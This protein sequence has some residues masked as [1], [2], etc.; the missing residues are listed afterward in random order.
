MESSGHGCPASTV[1]HRGV[2]MQIGIMGLGY[3]G[4]PLAVA[5]AEAGETVIGVD[6]DGRRVEALRQGRSF[7]EDIDD[8]RLAGIA[9]RFTATTRPAALALADAVIICVPTPLTPNR[10]PDLTPL[11]DAGRTLASVLQ[12]GQLVVLES[13]TYPGTTRERLAPLLEESGLAAGRDFALAF[14]PE[15]IDP[16]RG[17]ESFHTTPKVV[18]G[19]TATCGDRAEALYG[20]VVEAVVRVS[21]PEVAEM[22]KLLENIFRSV[23][24]ALVNELAE[25]A[26]RMGIEIHEV[27]DAAA[28]KPY[29]FMRFD[30]G[31]G[32]GGHC[33][34]VDPFYLSWKARELE[35][36]TEFIEL[37]GKVNQQAP[38]V[39]VDKVQRRLNELG[40]AVRGAKVAR[41]RRRLQARPLRRPRVARAEDPGAAAGARGR[42]GLPRRAGAVAAGPRPGERLAEDVLADCDVAVLVTPQP[43]ID[44]HAIADR[45]PFVDLRGITRT[46]RAELRPTGLRV[47]AEVPPVAP[48]AEA[49]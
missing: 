40:T 6:V 20:R 43:G 27:V 10:E 5:F 17:Q 1:S 3:V 41:P 8:E 36:C 7:V 11:L 48:I 45:V 30:P 39:A 12:P 34:P 35:F 18:G 47:L 4:L 22:A 28:T 38:Y 9:G 42:G 32:M 2:D 21:S 49:A 44:F 29:G 14:S 25:L 26:D 19:L 37:A 31:P 16:G 13:T 33:L 23:N 15:R 46:R 24:I